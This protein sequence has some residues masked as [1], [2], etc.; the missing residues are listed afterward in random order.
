M[1]FKA[2][3]LASSSHQSSPSGKLGSRAGPL[4]SQSGASPGAVDQSERRQP[5]EIK[6]LPG[7]LFQFLYSR[8]QFRHV[9]ALREQCQSPHYQMILSA[10]RWLLA[11][12]LCWWKQLQYDAL[13]HE[14]RWTWQSRC[15]DDLVFLFKMLPTNWFQSL[16]D[17]PHYRRQVTGNLITI[18]TL[19]VMIFCESVLCFCVVFQTPNKRI[20]HWQAWPIINIFSS[21]KVS[22]TSYNPS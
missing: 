9:F 6:K 12:L 20:E 8:Q 19:F 10:T 14:W 5:G 18:F 1:T 21:F 2:A 15:W 7:N 22:L 16:N 3:W 17:S 13:L 4:S 11:L